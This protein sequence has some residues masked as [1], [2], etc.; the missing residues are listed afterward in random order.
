MS[1]TTIVI[2]KIESANMGSTDALLRMDNGTQVSIDNLGMA[3]TDSVF[4]SWYE[5]L[6]FLESHKTMF[7]S[8]EFKPD[9][10]TGNASLDAWKDANGDGALEPFE[11]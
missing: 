11:D 3:T 9:T 5:I 4:V 10:R 6:E 2:V 7:I 8:N 1:D